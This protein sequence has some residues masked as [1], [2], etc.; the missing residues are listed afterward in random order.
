MKLIL[1]ING[2]KLLLTPAQAD[3]LIDLLHGVEHLEH[4]YMGRNT[5]GAEYM[6]FI[7]PAVVRDVVK[8]GAMSDVEYDAM[9]FITKQYPEPKST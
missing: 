7:K 9:V 1:E 2:T 8:F 6:D 3:G 5:G 4:K